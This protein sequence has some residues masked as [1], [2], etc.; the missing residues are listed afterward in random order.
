M[1]IF[2][3]FHK[4]PDVSEISYPLPY[5][6][7]EHWRKLSFDVKEFA[8][9]KVCSPKLAMMSFGF[10]LSCFTAM[11]LSKSGEANAVRYLELA[12]FTNICAS[13]DYAHH[14]SPTSLGYVFGTRKVKRGKEKFTLVAIGIRGGHY[15]A[16]WASNAKLGD[17]GLHRGFEEASERLLRDF[18]TYLALKKVKGPVYVWI[19]GYSRAGGIAASMAE[20]LTQAI[21]DPSVSILHPFGKAE[22]DQDHLY[23][24]TFAAPRAGYKGCPLRRYV[25]HFINP[26][27]LVPKIPFIGYGFGRNGICHELAITEE[28]EEKVMGRLDMEGLIVEKHAFHAMAIDLLHILDKDRRFVVDKDYTGG[29]KRFLDDLCETMESRL[30][31]EAYA[32]YIQDGLVAL[33]SLVDEQEVH[34]YEKLASFLRAIFDGVASYYGILALLTKLASEKTQWKSLLR[35]FVEKAI[36]DTPELE[37]QDEAILTTIAGLLHF[38]RPSA[39]EMI[40]YYPTIRDVENAKSVVYAHEPVRYLILL[41]GQ[42]VDLAADDGADA[43]AAPQQ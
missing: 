43:V 16:E 8:D 9:S 25:H 28:V 12:N 42:E 33:G 21:N 20:R 1:G 29:Q 6:G 2:D 22:L 37:G 31:R 11:D 7:E 10:A 41:L 38:L 23:V 5:A 35:P 15:G 18:A 40:S 34:P 26:E 4:I 14:A 27:D 13:E 3:F 17:D 30:P 32:K 24:H 19:C 39:K 36:E